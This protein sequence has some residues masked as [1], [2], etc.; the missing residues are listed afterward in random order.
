MLLMPI[1]SLMYSTSCRANIFKVVCSS[2]PLQVCMPRNIHHRFIGLS[3]SRIGT[4]F[5]SV[6]L[7]LISPSSM[8]TRLPSIL[9]W[10]PIFQS[11]W[12]PSWKICTQ[13]SFHRGS[14]MLWSFLPSL[15]VSCWWSMMLIH[16]FLLTTHH[17]LRTWST[18]QKDV[19]QAAWLSR[20]CCLC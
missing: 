4:C 20:G 16:F 18:Q 8:K 2:H 10:I 17:Q 6:L 1:L 14:D 5:V 9:P 12:N 15:S 3:W 13:I 11:M 19:G 7:R